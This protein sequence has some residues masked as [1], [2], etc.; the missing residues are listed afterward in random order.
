MAL[1]QSTPLSMD[2]PD[3]AGVPPLGPYPPVSIVVDMPPVHKL[4]LP[5]Y[6]Q[7]RS[8][9]PRGAFPPCAF[10]YDGGVRQAQA[11]KA[12]RIGAQF[13][14]H[15]VPAIVKPI[16]ALWNE[17]I[18]FLF[19]SLGVIFGFGGVRYWSR[20]KVGE[21]VLIFVVVLVMFYFGISSF[22]RAR[23]ISRS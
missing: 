7:F 14:K 2:A 16:H 9:T 22:L 3:G 13:V 10:C 5:V 8:R 18:G 11:A 15:I 19:L 4:L 1:P 12:A 17:V 23:K 21:S 20:G 6:R